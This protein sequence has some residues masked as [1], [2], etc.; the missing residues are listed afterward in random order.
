MA[1]QGAYFK[2]PHTEL[3]VEHYILLIVLQTYVRSIS[4]WI[5]RSVVPNPTLGPCFQKSEDTNTSPLPIKLG[6]HGAGPIPS[7]YT[8][9]TSYSTSERVRQI[10]HLW[11]SRGTKKKCESRGIRWS[12]TWLYPPPDKIV[13]I[14]PISLPSAITV[15]AK[16][17]CNAPGILLS[18]RINQ[19]P[20]VPRL[21]VCRFLLVW[22]P[23]SYPK[24]ARAPNMSWFS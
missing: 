2:I 19:P 13:P 20:L 17:C 4:V 3:L 6:H 1:Q 15:A 10:P 8:L 11:I 18:G 14:T 12:Q 5:T 24:S 23:P 21:A 9:S 7:C 22:R 16:S